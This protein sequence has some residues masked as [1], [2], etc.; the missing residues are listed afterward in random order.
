METI[1]EVAEPLASIPFSQGATAA[2]FAPAALRQAGNIARTEA[3]YLKS[4]VG[5][6]P[7][8]KAAG[9][10]RVAE[11]YARAPQIEAANFAQ[12]YEIALD[13]AVS[14]P[15]ARNRVRTG[16]V[17]SADLDA[18]LAKVNQPKWTAAVKKDLGVGE[19]VSLTNPKVFDDVRARDDISGPYKVVQEI[20]SIRVPDDAFKK[21]DNL[22]VTPLYGDTGEA[23]ATNAYITNLKNQL[24]EG[25][26]G[27]KLLK[28]IQ[29]MRQQAQNVYRTEKAGNPVSPAAKAE[30]DAK[31]NAAR[32][33]EELIDDNI[34]NIQ[35]RDAFIKARK[36]MAQTYDF[37]AA[38]DFGTGQID[39]KVFAKM[40]SDGK[41]VSGVVA[42]LGKIASVYPEIAVLSSPDKKLLPAFTRAGPGGALGGI[43]GSAIGTPF[44]GGPIGAVI[45]AGASE[46]IRRT[47]A[48]KMASPSFQASR[49]MP[50]DYRPQQPVN[51]LRPVEPGASNIV[52]FDPRNALLEPEIRPN[53]VFGQSAMGDV[54]PVPPN[55]L[56][57][58]LEAPSP[59]STIASLRSEEARRTRMARMTEA[60][61][62]AAEG[63]TP[64]APTSGEV[65]FDLDPISGKLRP[66]SQGIRGATPETMQDYM[67]TLRSATD[68][69][70]SGQKFAL[71][72]AEKVAFEKT[73]VD[74]AEIVPG[75][76]ALNDKAIA[77]K[78][79]DR[80]WVQD[81]LQKARQKEAA[82]A[83]IETRS[84]N[85]QEIAAARASRE[86]MFDVAE[87]MEENLRQMRPDTSRK[88]QG[89]KTRAA[90]RNAL[91]GDVETINKLV[92]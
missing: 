6:I 32:V 43:I 72:A 64:R 34:P 42:E 79:M 62:A 1:G 27:T 85:A 77:A 26:N 8:V 67:S 4:A 45:G 80:A 91:R 57:R 83:E 24:S 39:P 20:P 90:F 19:N 65:L 17:G 89:P 53:F 48:N 70:S 13:P 14:N 18:R 33:L 74:L 82:F 7:S 21:L 37:E 10:A 35:A 86:R 22:Q 55:A 75:F 59:Q 44:I 52:P 81:A 49:A 2:A 54:Q 5:E 25:G 40:V 51:M 46:I 28:S 15:S 66:V 31:M 87:M 11:S 29:D 12:K 73:R 38:T 16:L 71:D 69:I 58:Q 30:A 36:K 41:P 60:E 84:K 47:A 68:K 63:R 78:M 23:A 61:I 88:V 76:K 50:T 92:E 9:E 56:P 3:G